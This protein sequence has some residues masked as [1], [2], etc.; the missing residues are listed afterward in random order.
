MYSL[1]CGAETVELWVP[2]MALWSA[3]S[4]GSME[5]L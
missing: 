2:D 3:G 5:F 1:G 4:G